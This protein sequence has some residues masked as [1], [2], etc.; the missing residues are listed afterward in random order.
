MSADSP[1]LTLRIPPELH[2][3]SADEERVRALRTFQKETGPAFGAASIEE[4]TFR[5]RASTAAGYVLNGQ[6]ESVDMAPELRYM[7]LFL[8]LLVGGT[9]IIANYNNDRRFKGQDVQRQLRRAFGKVVKFSTKEAA[10]AQGQELLLLQKLD[11]AAN[12][13]PPLVVRNFDRC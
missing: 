6:R 7:R 11:R 8:M 12:P 2:P 5:I 4:Q 3:P 10:K 1:I 9:D 13:P